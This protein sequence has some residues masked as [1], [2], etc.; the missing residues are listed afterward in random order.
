ME[1]TFVALLLAGVALPTI[2]AQ[3]SK[4]GAVLALKPS[5]SNVEFS[6]SASV[7]DGSGTCNMEGTA[8]QIAASENQKHRWVWNDSSSQCVARSCEGYCGASASG[9]IDGQYNKK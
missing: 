8:Q 4:P 1:R 5:N 7:R 2:A 6:I 3:Y 9:L